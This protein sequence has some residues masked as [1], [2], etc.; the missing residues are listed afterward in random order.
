MNAEEAHAVHGWEDVTEKLDAN[1][2]IGIALIIM[3]LIAVAY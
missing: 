2:V 1:Q 3:G